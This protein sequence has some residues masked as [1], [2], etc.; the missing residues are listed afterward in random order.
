LIALPAQT[1]KISVG[2]IGSENRYRGERY[3]YVLVPDD[4]PDMSQLMEGWVAGLA[5]QS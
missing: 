1:V 3:E 2:R 4:P 5:S